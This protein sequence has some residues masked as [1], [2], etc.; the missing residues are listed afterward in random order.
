VGISMIEERTV[1]PSPGAYSSKAADGL[2]GNA[3]E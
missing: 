2:T 3:Q 1:Q